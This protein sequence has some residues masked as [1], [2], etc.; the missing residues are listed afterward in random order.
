MIDS[1]ES[2][3]EQEP[4]F[5]SDAHIEEALAAYEDSWMARQAA[6]EREQIA[7][8]AARVPSRAIQYPQVGQS[9]VFFHRPEVPH[10][11]HDLE[12]GK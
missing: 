8:N 6:K 12:G 2:G 9:Q 3:G 10:A 5:D 1:Q 11:K 7:A 4:V